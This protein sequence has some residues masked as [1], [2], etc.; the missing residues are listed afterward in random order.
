MKA[1]DGFSVAG[2]I[3]ILSKLRSFHR[4]HLLGFLSL[5]FDIGVQISRDL[6]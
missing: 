1:R 4:D 6:K 3:D 2:G 5:A